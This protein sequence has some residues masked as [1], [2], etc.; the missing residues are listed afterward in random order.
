MPMFKLEDNV[1]SLSDSQRL[2][3]AGIDLGE[4]DA[5]YIYFPKLSEWRF[6]EINE[7]VEFKHIK[8]IKAY[9]LDKLSAKLP[10]GLLDCRDSD[11]V[12]YSLGLFKESG[13]I[14]YLIRKIRA[15]KGKEAIAAAVELLVL[16]KKE[17]VE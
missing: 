15:F 2:T 5:K 3:E 1:T 4:A 16:L 13:D 6:L 14:F 10:S 9:R 17:G 8:A 12:Y 11:D 7:D